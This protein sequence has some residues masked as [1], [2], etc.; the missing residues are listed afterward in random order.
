[1]QENIHPSDFRI[2]QY[3]RLKV[4]NQRPVL[5]WFTGLS[6][7]GKSTLANGTE[8]G[9]H[10]LGFKTYLLDGDN[11]RCG[12]NNDLDFSREDRVE[13]IRRI[14]EVSRLMMDAGLIV[15]AA[16]ITPLEEDRKLIQST[17]GEENYLEVFVDC[18]LEVC[19]RRDVK[20]LY[21]KAR[22]G[23]I[24]NFTG[25]NSPYELPS[26]PFMCIKS[27]EE[28][29]SVSVSKIIKALENKINL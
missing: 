15:I 13:N 25:I 20:G 12:L 3:D 2:K 5:L 11:I 1:M 16:F 19:E 14:A 29:T 18:P 22:K 26:N 21:E 9:L 23:L 4:M 8:V 28:K 7:S 27:H 6:G 24:A 10:R 17:V